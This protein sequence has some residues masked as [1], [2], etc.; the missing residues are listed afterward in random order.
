MSE[1]EK[2]TRRS[3]GSKLALAW[4]GGEMVLG[5]TMKH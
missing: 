4:V 5:A 1:V 2:L 3:K